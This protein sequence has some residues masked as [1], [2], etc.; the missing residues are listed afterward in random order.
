MRAVVAV[1]VL[2]AGCVD[3][4]PTPPPEP[5]LCT[6]DRTIDGGIAEDRAV[7]AGQGSGDSFVPYEDGGA[8]DIIAGFQGGFMITPTIRV[9]AGTESGDRICALVRLT[10]RLESGDAIVTGVDRMVVLRRQGSY[11]YSDAINDLLSSDRSRLVDQT[12]L[13]DVEV[14]GVGFGGSQM[15]VLR[16][17]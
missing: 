7:V 13:L 17:T 4:E 6:V 3:C 11:F 14:R 5:E 16:L 9:E 12:L 2:S 15:L 1:A 8:T 10:H